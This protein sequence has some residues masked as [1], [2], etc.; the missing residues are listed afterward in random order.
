VKR[1]E[2]ILAQCIDDTK[3]GRASVEECLQKYPSMRRRLEPLL[4]VALTIQESPDVKPSPAF[5]ISARVWLMDQIHEGQVGARWP[6][7]R[8]F[9]SPAPYI[10]RF[11]TSMAGIIL[12]VVLAISGAGIGTVYASQSSLPGD[13]LYPVKMATE[14]AEMMFTG[15]DVAR[16]ERALSFTDKRLKEMIALAE[17][18]RP[19]D[20]DLAVQEYGYALGM[21]LAMMERTADKGLAAGNITALVAEATTRHLAILDDLWDMVPEEARV[22]VAGAE[23]VSE[24]G[25]FRA[26]VALASNNT[27]W[28]VQLN[29]AAMNGRLNRIALRVR[30]AEAVQIALRQFE[31]MSVFD[32]EISQIARQTNDNA[33]VVDELIASMTSEELEELA[34]LWEMAPEQ[35]RPAIESVMGNLM[36]HHQERIRALEHMGVEIPAPPVIPE[37]LQERLQERSQEQ[38]QDGISGQTTVPGAASG[39]GYQYGPGATGGP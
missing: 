22:V 1:F 39:T 35:T 23:N 4:R 16:A 28:A 14:Q 9:A 30:N 27:V 38:Q 13:T 12:A 36:M 37:R 2:E 24:A 18:G 34:R 5:K 33:G 32:E 26:M 15:D 8:N 6:W 7:S 21:A 17:K 10:K 31:D 25:Y 19:R 11:A 20:L 29:F 3:A